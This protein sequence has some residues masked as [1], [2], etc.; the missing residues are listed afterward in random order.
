MRHPGEIAFDFTRYASL[1]VRRRDAELGPLFPSGLEWNPQ[2]YDPTAAY[3]EKYHL[4]LVRTPDDAPAEDPRRL[5][6]GAW[7]ADV[8]LLSHRGRFWLFDSAPIER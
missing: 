8:R 3:A 5:T 1:P 6:F 4:V 2:L 7:A